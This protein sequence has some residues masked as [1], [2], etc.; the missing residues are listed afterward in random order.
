MRISFFKHFLYI[1]YGIFIG[2]LLS[3][4]SRTFTYL[5][6]NI[7]PNMSPM[8]FI[9][10]SPIVTLILSMVAFFIEI[11]FYYFELHKETSIKS[12]ITGI[13]YGILTLVLINKWLFIINLVFNPF[14]VHYYILFKYKK[15][16]Q[17]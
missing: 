11:V 2:V 4:T 7:Q 14:T 17:S 12:I 16:N 3:S 9:V 13:S 10:F 8:M 15:T 6:Q 5:Y 1:V